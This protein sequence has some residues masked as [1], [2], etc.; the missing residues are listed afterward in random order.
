MNNI[1]K[2]LVFWL[3]I[4]LMVLL[5][6]NFA[7]EAQKQALKKDAEISYSEFMSAS[8]NGD[9]AE[10]TIKGEKLVGKYTNDKE[11]FAKVPP[12]ENVVDRLD[13]AKV[14]I[15]ADEPDPPQIT[16]WHIII[17]FAPVLILIGFWLFIM[18]QMNGKGGG[19]AMGFGK[20]RA[21]ML[22]ET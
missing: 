20:S 2:N 9:V 11:F 22:N 17:N 14:V 6:A 10:V 19:G 12:K 4:I 15:K 1:N 8:K 13:G 21:K 3:G 18:R 16:L 5:L 7:Q